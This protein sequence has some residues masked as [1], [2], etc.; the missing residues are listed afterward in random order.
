MIAENL[1]YAVG[2]GGRFW[3]LSHPPAHAVAATMT[4]TITTSTVS[5]ST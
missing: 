5:A 3:T 2:I 1:K 4:A